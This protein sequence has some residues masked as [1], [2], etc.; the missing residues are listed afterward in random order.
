MGRKGVSKR[1]PK[2]SKSDSNDNINHGSSMARQGE[3]LSPVQ[4]L[5]N[6]KEAPRDRG[7][8]NP[9]AG[10]NKKNRKGK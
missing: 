7:G 5:V 2:K 1:K 8:S 3:T 6:A 4:A 10:T 9:A